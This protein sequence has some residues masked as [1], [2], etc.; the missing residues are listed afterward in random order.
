M[1]QAIF[2]YVNHAFIPSWNQPVLSNEGKVS[3]SR[4]QR[5][6]G[7]LSTA[8]RCPALYL[9]LILVPVLLPRDRLQLIATTI[10][11]LKYGWKINTVNKKTA[12]YEDVLN[13]KHLAQ[14]FQNHFSSCA[15]YKVWKNKKNY[16]TDCISFTRPAS[17]TTKSGQ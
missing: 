4:K 3:C 10:W 15:I 9:K 16:I 2:T 7:A 13:W 6:S 12:K 11:L 14:Y 8:T 1:K 17:R 5:E